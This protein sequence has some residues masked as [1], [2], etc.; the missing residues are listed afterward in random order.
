[1]KQNNEINI[2]ILEDEELVRVILEDYLQGYDY[3]IFSFE[4]GSQALSAMSSEDFH[5]AIVDMNT[6]DMDGN[7]FILEVHKIN[8][9]CKFIIHTGSMGENLSDSLREIGM[10]DCDILIKPVDDMELFISA[11]NRL[12]NK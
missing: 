10:E 3:K 6:P 12:I 2:L 9:S 5:V 7:E 8:P 11:I 1:M 4:T